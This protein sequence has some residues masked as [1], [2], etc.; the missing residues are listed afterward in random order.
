MKSDLDRLMLERELDA[1]IVTGGEEFNPARYYLTNGAQITHGTIFKLR[2]KTPLLV[3]SRMELEEAQK[4]GL[5]VKT[6]AELNYY[7]RYKE[8]EGDSN[9]ATAL[10]WSDILARLGLSAG[11]VGLYGTWQINKTLALYQVLLAELT[12][13]EFVVEEKETLLEAAML[14]KDAD[15]IARIK[16]VAE[17]A[18]ATME[19]AWERIASLRAQGDLLLDENGTPVTIG[20]IK[21][22][23]RRE[24]MARG[25]EDTNMIFAQGRDGGFPSQP[26]RGRYASAAGAG[27]RI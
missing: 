23:V 24:L 18:N 15:E 21:D 1:I 12:A 25:L 13:F 20:D 10:H 6:D 11:R 2:D 16:S 9:R 8:A 17:R 22:L 7:E 4:S 27:D 19:V 14:T 3:C 26:W 5:D